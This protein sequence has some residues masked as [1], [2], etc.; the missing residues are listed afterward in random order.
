[1]AFKCLADRWRADTELVSHAAK[2]VA[3]AVAAANA[4]VMNG[5]MAGCSEIDPVG[6]FFVVAYLR[7]T[8][9]FRAGRL[10][11]HPRVQEMA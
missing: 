4:A 2:A 6:L 11:K 1:V 3:H 5:L 10:K 9:L 8:A 7:G